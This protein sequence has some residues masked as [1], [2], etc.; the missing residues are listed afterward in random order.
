MKVTVYDPVNDSSTT[1]YLDDEPSALGEYHG[2]TKHS[3]QEVRVAWSEKR[4]RWEIL[5]IEPF[6]AARF[7]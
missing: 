6:N 3:D 5:W 4:D 1:A 7:L 2:V